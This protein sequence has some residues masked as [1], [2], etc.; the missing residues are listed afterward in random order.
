MRRYGELEEGEK[1]QT[2]V[3]FWKK[4]AKH[5]EEREME[6]GTASEWG[7]VATATRVHGDE[8]GVFRGTHPK[9]NHC[10]N[11]KINIEKQKLQQPN[12]LETEAND[13]V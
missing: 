9:L 4:M 13:N 7:E 3:T 11:C 1:W 2:Q 5:I 8:E 12:L 10:V 6:E